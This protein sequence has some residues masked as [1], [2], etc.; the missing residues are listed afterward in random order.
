MIRFS[1]S[2]S[3]KKKA[4]ASVIPIETF[5]YS[6]TVEGLRWGNSESVAG[7]STVTNIT[8][9]TTLFACP[10]RTWESGVIKEPPADV[11][12]NVTLLDIAKF[13][14]WEPAYI[15]MTTMLLSN[16]EVKQGY[17]E[18]KG[19]SET[20]CAVCLLNNEG[21]DN[22]TSFDGNSYAFELILGNK[23]L[24]EKITGAAAEFGDRFKHLPPGNSG[25]K[26]C[27]H[28]ANSH[29]FNANTPG[30]FKSLDISS[31]FLSKTE[32]PNASSLLQHATWIS[33]NL[34]LT[35]AT[36]W[37]S[38][39]N[40]DHVHIREIVI[41]DP[42]PQATVTLA[43]LPG[44]TLEKIYEESGTWVA[45]DNTRGAS[46]FVIAVQAGLYN[47]GGFFNASADSIKEGIKFGFTDINT[48]DLSAKFGDEGFIHYQYTLLP[49]SD[50]IATTPN[51][52]SLGLTTPKEAVCKTDDNA[53][54]TVTS[55]TSV[56]ELIANNDTIVFKLIQNADDTAVAAASN[57]GFQGT[58]KAGFNACG[59]IGGASMYVFADALQL[60]KLDPATNNSAV[61]L[62]WFRGGT[63]TYDA[64]TPTPTD[65]AL[66]DPQKK[67]VSFL[68][69]NF[70]INSSDNPRIVTL[71]GKPFVPADGEYYQKMMLNYALSV[72]QMNAVDGQV[73]G[74]VPF[75]PSN[76]PGQ[77][78]VKK[79][80][81]EEATGL[82]GAFSSPTL[83]NA[84]YTTTPFVTYHIGGSS[85]L[86]IIIIGCVVGAIALAG[87]G[88]Y[89][90]TNRGD[91]A[92]A[93]SSGSV[94]D[95][96][97]EA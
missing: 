22:P 67:P 60:Q 66:D 34:P 70:T 24:G 56:G 93:A 17:F 37:K 85:N 20:P 7:Q 91:G 54:G 48:E 28:D 41:H 74:A 84:E 44:S 2:K 71:E 95:D 76:A 69:A 49:P 45:K 42:T 92:Q 53:L 26:E 83:M 12:D 1:L 27:T 87:I 52:N 4:P 16:A 90:Y 78:W 5:E 15:P 72:T 59:E 46:Y 75:V 11:T 31:T 35:A 73:I 55:A 50:L 9:A 43:G 61:I 65:G 81:F 82:S 14:E 88:Y 19:V 97:D 47:L 86:L 57:Y 23:K 25:F 29:L 32:T 79:W 8:Q 13:A 94:A 64:T 3:S 80:K 18:F 58:V 38:S 77:K 21:A 62:P 39:M 33:T 51:A 40:L 10:A 96:T 6:G 68:V 30:I 89:F 63:I 36:D